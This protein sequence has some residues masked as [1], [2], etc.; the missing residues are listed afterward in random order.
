M[1]KHQVSKPRPAKKSIADEYG[2]PDT[3]RSK[4]GCDAID[5]PCTNNT[6]PSLLRATARFSHRKRLTPPFL[7]QCSWPDMTACVL[8]GFIAF[9]RRRFLDRIFAYLHRAVL[10][11]IL[12]DSNPTRFS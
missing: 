7:V 6:V 12:S 8:I 4:V 9:P 11:R 1:S 3:C 10:L 5:E 2:R